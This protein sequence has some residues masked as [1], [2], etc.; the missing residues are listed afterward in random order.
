MPNKASSSNVF[1][2][3]RHQLIDLL[4][5]GCKPHT[6]WRIG[7][8]HEKFGFIR[9]EA[10]QKPSSET[11]KAYTPPPYFGSHGI[12]A[13]LNALYD[14]QPDHWRPVIDEGNIIGLNGKGQS[15]GAAISLEPAGQFELSGAPLR[16]LHETAQELHDH[17]QT[18]R[19]IARSLG[20]GFS[21][22]GFHPTGTR[23]TMPWMPKSRYAL[24]RTYMPKVGSLGIDMMQR[25]CTV[26]VNLDFDSEH[27]MVRKM[28]VSAALQ[29]MTIALF[30]NSPFFE[31]KPNGF[32]SNRARVWTDTDRARSGTHP[33]VFSHDLSFERYVD[34]VLDVPMYFIM[35][36]GKM[37]NVAGRSFHA[38]LKGERQEG[39]EDTRPTLEDFS[40][41]LTTVFPDIRLKQFLEIRC[42]DVGSPEM[43]LALSALWTGLLYDTT[44][45]NSAWDL[46][47]SHPWEAY[48]QLYKQVPTQGLNTPFGKGTLRSFA[49]R[50]V[51]LALKGL[52]NRNIIDDKSQLSEEI[53]LAPLLALAEG[54]PT[55]AEHWLNRYH[56]AWMGDINRIFLESEV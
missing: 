55:Q 33:Y 12:Q 30:A 53:Y 19:P 7:T 50:V 47:R 54:A 15:A 27:D 56:G 9:P 48:H 2:D 42:A 38:W 24:M 32:L 29:P 40:H 37:R 21:L 10:S 28:Q 22:L 44:A 20:I 26:Q 34:W 6:A 17:F 3:S 46:I 25:T 51:T 11:L 4:A 5:Q 23:A 49:S 36:N 35:R 31:G 18:L 13:L 14:S 45:L 52:Q 16:T 41:H 1:I 39:L 43:I 8:E